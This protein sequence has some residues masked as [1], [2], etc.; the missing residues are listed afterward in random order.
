MSNQN[1]KKNPRIEGALFNC[2]WEL[3]MDNLCCLDSSF[4]L[5]V[6][7]NEPA[8][9]KVIAYVRVQLTPYP[10]PIRDGTLLARPPP[11]SLPPPNIS[12][13]WMTPTFYHY[14]FSNKI[15][16]IEKVK[17]LFTILGM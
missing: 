3:G 2:T 8:K 17:D 13:L 7:C 9:Q 15:E 6:F 16:F 5:L 4:S 1:T 12:T 14:G 10:L 11:P